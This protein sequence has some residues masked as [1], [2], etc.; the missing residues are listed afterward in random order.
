M[1]VEVVYHHVHLLSF[2]PRKSPQS[3]PRLV[4]PLKKWY[5]ILHEVQKPSVPQRS[6]RRETLPHQDHGPQKQQWCAIPLQ[7]CPICKMILPDWSPASPSSW[8]TK[9]EKQGPR[10]SL[11]AEVTDNKP[12]FDKNI[13]PQ[14]IAIRRFYFWGN[15]WSSACAEECIGRI[16]CKLVIPECWTMFTNALPQVFFRIIHFM[17]INHWSF[18]GNFHYKGI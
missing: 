12:V 4:F 7:F 2:H 1:L 5:T 9:A 18:H 13:T 6:R 15:L 3:C 8:F 10:S 16:V 11:N 14:T 17:R